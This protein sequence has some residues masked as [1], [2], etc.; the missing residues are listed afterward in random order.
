MYSSLATQQL[1]LKLN[2]N[3]ITG[4]VDGEG[5]FLISISRSPTHKIG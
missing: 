4:F 5:S 2:P 1:Y 3:C